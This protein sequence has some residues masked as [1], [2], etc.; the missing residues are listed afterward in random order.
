[1]YEPEESQ[2]FVTEDLERISQFY[3]SAVEREKHLILSTSFTIGMFSVECGLSFARH[4][5]PIVKLSSSMTAM[6][7][8]K[9]EWVALQKLMQTD[10][11]AITIYGFNVSV[12]ECLGAKMLTISNIEG[13]YFYLSE[14]DVNELFKLNFCIIHKLDMLYNLNFS[15][16]YTKFIEMIQDLNSDK[17]LDV[18]FAFCEILPSTQSYGI[19]ECLYYLKDK[20]LADVNRYK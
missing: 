9:D 1:M 11:Q 14:S 4:F 2:N 16:Y 17:P 18:M 20:L 6:T 13:K 8:D 7:F 12:T 5:K 10:G 15:L 19:C 3:A